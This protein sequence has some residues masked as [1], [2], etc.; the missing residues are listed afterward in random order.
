MKC[1]L[2]PFLQT[3]GLF[4]DNPYYT[5]TDAEGRF[6][7]RDIPEGTYEVIAWHPFIPMQEGTVTIKPGNKVELNFQFNGEDERRRLYQ[8]DTKG[9]R[10][11]TWF[12]SGKKFY[13]EKRVDDP[14]EILQKF[15][16]SDRY[17][18]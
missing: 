10:F 16:N 4:V 14:V 9:Y 6:E 3:H 12:D 18:D 1:N 17:V 15:D 8:N 13:G 5:V 11:N 7:I 2:H